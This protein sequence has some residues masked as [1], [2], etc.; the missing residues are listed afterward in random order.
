MYFTVLCR[1]DSQSINMLR[2]YNANV[3]ELLAV[4]RTQAKYPISLILVGLGWG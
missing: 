2:Y 3:N 1:K 4:L